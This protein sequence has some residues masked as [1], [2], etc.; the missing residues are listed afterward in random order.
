MKPH[1]T[2][3]LTFYLPSIAKF[4]G[5]DY[6]ELYPL[7]DWVAPKFPDYIT[8]SVIPLVVDEISDDSR[9]GD[10][11][12]LRRV[13]RELIDLGPG[14]DVYQPCD[15]AEEEMYYRDTFDHSVVGG[16]MKH[17]QALQG[18]IPMVPYAWLYHHDLE[19]L[20]GKLQCFRDN[21]FDGYCLWVWE[22]DL[23]SDMIRKAE[24]VY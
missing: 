10:S 20:Q 9:R 7:F 2:V 17:L 21:G 8:G 14:P 18:K 3:R 6:D 12:V 23:T 16:Q 24:G 22:A 15:P 13:I 4:F 11:T 1:L 5:I 19:T